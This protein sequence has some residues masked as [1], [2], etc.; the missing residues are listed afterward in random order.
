MEAFRAS[1]GKKT[2]EFK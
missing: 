1:L 2:E